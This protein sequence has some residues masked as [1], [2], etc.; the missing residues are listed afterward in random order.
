[1]QPH[2]GD[3]HT[4]SH[5]HTGT[6]GGL[7]FLACYSGH[8]QLQLHVRTYEVKFQG[9]PTFPSQ[10]NHPKIS[11]RTPRWNDRERGEEPRKDEMWFVKTGARLG[12]ASVLWPEAHS[13]VLWVQGEKESWLL[14]SEFGLNIVAAR[15]N[16]TWQI[17]AKALCGVTSTC[18]YKHGTTCTA[19]KYTLLEKTLI[20][21]WDLQVF[22][23]NCL[24]NFFFRVSTKL[25]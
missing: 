14:H 16:Y 23:L 18:R 4:D 3:K 15:L 7:K 19:W 20:L 11:G 5:T 1:M 21:C 25:F 12:F 24:N 2:F 10:Y 17:S 13:F 9:C 6:T 22:S 8:I